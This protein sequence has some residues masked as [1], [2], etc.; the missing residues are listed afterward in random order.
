[1]ATKMKILKLMQEIKGHAQITN[2]RPAPRAPLLYLMQLRAQ[3]SLPQDAPRRR[4]TVTME[5]AEAV[6][7]LAVKIVH[8]NP[9]ESP[10]PVVVG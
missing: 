8:V 4:L 6:A 5:A 1:M 9:G 2:R 3:Q 7:P 10:L